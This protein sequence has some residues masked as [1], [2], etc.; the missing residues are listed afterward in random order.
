MD[1]FSRLKIPCNFIEAGD[2]L[3]ALEKTLN[4][5]IDLI[6][7]NWNMPKMSGIDYLKQVRAIQN[8]EKV[9]I[10]MITSEAARYNVIEA[11]KHGAT[12]YIVKPINNELFTE[13]VSKLNL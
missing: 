11:L 3:E 6:F 9:P 7:L 2:G 8:Y 4:N 13:K 1:H 10:I 5:L 12:D